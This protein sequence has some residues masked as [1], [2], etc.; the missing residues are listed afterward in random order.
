VIVI[1]ASRVT[2][3]VDEICYASAI[4]FYAS[5]GCVIVI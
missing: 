4:S 2:S 1:C 5:M 3:N